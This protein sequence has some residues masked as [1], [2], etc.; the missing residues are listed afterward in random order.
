VLK[1]LKADE[2]THRIPVV[3]LTSSSEDPDIEECYRLGAN[4]YVVKPVQFESFSK[5]VSELGMYWML[6]NHP[7]H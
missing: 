2:R 3:V 7:P 6:L 5:A 1:R 4:S